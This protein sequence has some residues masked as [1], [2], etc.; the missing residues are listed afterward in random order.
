MFYFA[1]VM[2]LFHFCAFILHCSLVTYIRKGI[3][4]LLS[5]FIKAASELLN[6]NY[7]LH[8]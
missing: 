3:S 7:K 4:R 5:T 6:T 8:R 1:E 2:I